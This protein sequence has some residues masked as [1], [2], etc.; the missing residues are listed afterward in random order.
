MLVCVNQ[1]LQRE[2]GSLWLDAKI[3]ETPPKMGFE[4]DYKKD[5]VCQMRKASMETGNYD[6]K[7]KRKENPLGWLCH[8]PKLLGESEV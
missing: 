6:E 3:F 5:R 7:G 4:S 1:A 8:P 2:F